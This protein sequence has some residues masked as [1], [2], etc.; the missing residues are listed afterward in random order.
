MERTLAPFAGDARIA[1]SG[2]AIDMSAKL[3]LALAAAVQEL[4]TNAAKYG[5]LSVPDGTLEVTWRR[6][7][8]GSIALDWI[9]R[10]GP[11]VVKPSRR[12]F[13][14]RLIQD[15]LAVD[16]GWRVT[17]DYAPEGL[18]CRMVIAGVRE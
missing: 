10:G 15:I 5:S 18:T 11:P 13:G 16:S 3:T 8:D 17:V 14:S 7:A 4:S 12:G 9:E 2:P 6:E 1:M